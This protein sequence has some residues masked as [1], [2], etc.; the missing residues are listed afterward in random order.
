[1]KT[2]VLAAGYATRLY[3][4]TKDRP[5]PLLDISGKPL[6]EHILVQIEKIDPS[7]T[8]T[9]V[10][11]HKFYPQ[12]ETWKADYHASGS[13]LLLDDGSTDESNRLG[14]IGDI[15]FCIRDQKI[16]EDLLVI[17][18]DNL[19]DMDLAPFLRFA[20]KKSPFCSV[21]LYDVKDFDLARNYGIVG[22]D[23]DQQVVSFEE[24]PKSPQST[25]S[26]MGVYYFP[27]K[28][29]G[30]MESYLKEGSPQDAPG[31]FIR[32][33][34]QR[35]AVYGYPCEGIWYDIGDL[36]SYRRASQSFETRKEE[37]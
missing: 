14:A 20:Q 25:L 9:I 15:H 27:K 28:V 21:M 18:G 5:K 31:F 34:H 12:F 36:E 37:R 11:N 3:P 17:A 10:V 26:A 32:W 30:Q 4:L 24:K 23:D 19:F 1:M 8:R 29:L 6:L 33:L 16:S 2:L 13:I 7:G 35:E 22:V